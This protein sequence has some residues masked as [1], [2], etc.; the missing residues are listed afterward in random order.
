MEQVKSTDFG[1]KLI[2]KLLA[3]ENI[4]IFQAQV[5]TASFNVKTRVLTLPMWKDVTPYTEDHLIGHEVGHALYTPEQ[6]WHDAVCANEEVFKT[7]LNVVEDARIEKLVMRKYPGLK[8]SFVKSYRGMMDTGFFGGSMEAINKMGLIDRI[9]T[10]YK[11]GVSAGVAFSQEEKQFIP[12]LDALESWDDVVVAAKAIYDY[13]LEKEEEK[14]QQK[15]DEDEADEDTDGDT[16]DEGASSGMND[17]DLREMDA[18]SGGTGE[19]DEFDDLFDDE[20]DEELAGQG[21]FEGGVS[22]KKV[23]DISSK[24][25]KALR[26]NINDHMVEDSDVEIFNFTLDP[27]KTWKDKVI[28]YKQILQELRGVKRVGGDFGG[29]NNTYNPKTLTDINELGSKL[30]KSWQSRNKKIVNHMVKE[31][32]MRKSATAYS[33][34]SISKTGVID[35]LKMNNYKI[36]DD[37]FRKVSVVADGK[38]H[39]FIMYLDMS[40]SMNEYIYE[41]VEQ[42]ILLAQFCKQIGVPFKVFGFT[43]RLRHDD[44]GFGREDGEYTHPQEFRETHISPLFGNSCRLLEIFSNTMNAADMSLMSK[45]IL[46]QYCEYAQKGTAVK[47]RKFDD[48]LRPIRFRYDVHQSRLFHLGGTPLNE[49]I[50]IG[51]PL[52]IDFRKKNNIEVMNT[53]ILSDGESHQMGVNGARMNAMTGY[54]AIRNKMHISVLNPHTNKTYRLMK[55]GFGRLTSETE[56][57]FNMYREAVG[58]NLIGYRIEKQSL[59]NIEHLADMLRGMPCTSEGDWDMVKKQG[60]CHITDAVCYDEVFVIGSKSINNAEN[61]MEEVESGSLTK[62]KLRTV[63]SKSQTSSKNARMM[64]TELAK[65]IA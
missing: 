36:T 46:T 9:N 7:Y 14:Q 11:C 53:F 38:N 59:R 63:F 23:P 48:A 39:G 31:F 57:I 30:Y 47:L 27:M 32:E 18:P 62:A 10:Y 60:W 64:L 51:I 19:S 44:Y 26:Q 37:I 22:G 54:Q 24:T 42:T 41:T 13:C 65:R 49:A 25:D 1:G 29:D 20:E 61:K 12:M 16:G 21:G 50:A 17:G 56:V 35:T 15:T 2:A 45:A 34:T 43:D 3:T 55:N 52:A 8:N 28:T 40:G 58:G 4:S 6:G 33:R 5:P